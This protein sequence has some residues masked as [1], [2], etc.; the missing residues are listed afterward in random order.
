MEKVTRR[1]DAGKLDKVERTPQ[2]G[3]RAPARLTRV[4]IFEY[5]NPDG[6]VRRELRPPEEV[7]A[8]DSLASLRG[9]PVTHL[10]V[11]EITPGNFGMFAK[12]H[13]GD[14]VEKDDIY[15]AADVVIQDGQ[16]VALVESGQLVEISLGYQALMDETP[17]T[18]NGEPYDAVQRSIRY[19]HAALG[20]K[21]W[22]RAGGNV[23]L[24][25]DSRGDAIPPGAEDGHTSPRGGVHQDHMEKP[26]K[27]EI[28]NGTEYEVGTPAHLAAVKRRDSETENFEKKIAD[29]EQKIA[30]ME[31]EK[32][33]LQDQL[34]DAEEE[35]E[36]EDTEEKEDSRV[37]ERAK[38]RAALLIAA[39]DRGVEVKEDAS[40]HEIRVAILGK[41]N[42]SAKLDSADVEKVAAVYEY[43]LQN[44]PERSSEGVARAVFD[45]RH[46]SAKPEMNPAIEAQKEYLA[47]LKAG[48][49]RAS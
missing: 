10:H 42:P 43:A 15:V 31:E 40:D 28:I 30:D 39:R 20:P 12:G 8:K 34:K 24:R 44:A 33:K 32:A 3:I 7:F 49:K 17:G 11:A 18:W 13:V 35:E 36:K 25:L 21:D 5:R 16:I 2:G 1:Y 14:N 22:G 41:L 37:A 29:L 45:S 6:S 46:G 23:A 19:N 38:V 48:A 27:I 26:M 4:G 9:A 47:R